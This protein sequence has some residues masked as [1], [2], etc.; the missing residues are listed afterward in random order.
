MKRPG[1]PDAQAAVELGDDALGQIV[2]VD[3]VVLRGRGNFRHAPEVGGDDAR[4]RALRDAGGR[5]QDLCC[6]RRRRT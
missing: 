6:R 5:C 2:A 1:L 3:F 4:S